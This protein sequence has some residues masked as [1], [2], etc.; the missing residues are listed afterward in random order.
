MLENSSC[1]Q[2]KKRTPEGAQA[3][4]VSSE[5]GYV[6]CKRSSRK[7]NNK[8]CCGRGQNHAMLEIKYVVLQQ[9]NTLLP[10]NERC[11]AC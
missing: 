2:E 3:K 1:R 6:F 8:E 7:H 11:V 9:I 4:S 5:G 10:S